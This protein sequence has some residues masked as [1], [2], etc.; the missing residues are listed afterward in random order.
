MGTLNK[1]NEPSDTLPLG[2]AADQGSLEI[3][4]LAGDAIL[5]K[6]Q[7]ARPSAPQP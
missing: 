2:G 4:L 7:P 5:L 1:A 6:R 3:A